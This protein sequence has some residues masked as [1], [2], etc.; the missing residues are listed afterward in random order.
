MT[1]A[2]RSAALAAEAIVAGAPDAYVD[3]VIA[4]AAEYERERARHYAL[5]ARW[6]DAEFWRARC[7]VAA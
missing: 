3:H 7:P 4:A 5:E 6:P 2:L 1:F